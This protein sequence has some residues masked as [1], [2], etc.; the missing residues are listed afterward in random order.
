M[1]KGEGERWRSDC[2][3]NTIKS[4]EKLLKGEFGNKSKSKG[5]VR[6]YDS[7]TN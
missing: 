6:D 5:D 4:G 2:G 1:V 3:S 7:L